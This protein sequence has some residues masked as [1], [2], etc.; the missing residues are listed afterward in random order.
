M[1]L[2]APRTMA[3]LVCLALM[4]PVAA[5]AASGSVAPPEAGT[6]EVEAAASVRTAV[7]PGCRSVNVIEFSDRT[8][9]PLLRR[10]AVRH[11]GRIRCEVRTKIRCRATLFQ[12]R[13]QLS[14]IA[15]RGRKRCEMASS[16]GQSASYRPGTRFRESYRYKL[17]LL[18]E[19]QRWS[20]PSNFCPKISNKR[21]TL[22]CRD[23]HSTTAPHRHVD[24]HS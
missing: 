21:R 12:G 17:T 11:T 15:S 10:Y 9:I 4:L 1:T 3:L 14:V 18:R 8:V 6:G 22:T 7:D 23:S 24:R 13:E 16:Y 5:S 19:R 20:G 2:S